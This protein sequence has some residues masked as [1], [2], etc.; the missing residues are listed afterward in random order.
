MMPFFEQYFDATWRTNLAWFAGAVVSL[1]W[2]PFTPGWV[3]CQVL[4]LFAYNL[5]HYFALWYF[6]RKY[7]F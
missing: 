1:S 3:I 7:N 5:I 2:N 6:K 4:A